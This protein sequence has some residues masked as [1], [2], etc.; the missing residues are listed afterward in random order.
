[1]KL[2]RNRSTFYRLAVRG[3]GQWQSVWCW[4]A[5]RGSPI[6]NEKDAHKALKALRAGDLKRRKRSI[7]NAG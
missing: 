7:V 2:P 3:L 5:G 4:Q 6:E 1:M